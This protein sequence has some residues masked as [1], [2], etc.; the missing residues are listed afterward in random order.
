[1]ALGNTLGTQYLAV[2]HQQ[3]TQFAGRSDFA[4]KM[5]IAFGSKV[6]RDQ[7]MALGQRWLQGDFRGLP[8]IDVLYQGEL[9]TARGAYELANNKIYLSASFL[10]TASTADIVG[11]LL[12]EIGHSLDGLLN[13]GDASGDEGALFSAF[14][15]GN[16]LS[17]AEILSLQTED[18]HAFIKLNGQLLLIE[19]ATLIGDNNNNTLNGTALADLMSGLGGD[20]VISGF[21]GN[22]TL[23]GGSGSD[24]LTGGAGNDVFALEYF[25]GAFNAVNQDVVSDFVRGQDKI[26]LRSLGIG[27]LGT[28]LA[29]TND[30]NGSAVITTQYN[31]LNGFYSLRLNGISRSTL[32]AVNFIFNTSIIN[33]SKIGTINGDDLFGGQ[34]SDTLNGSAGDDRLFGEQG[35]DTLIGG[36]GSDYLTGGAGNDIFAL[37]YFTG[38]FNAVNQ[39]VVSDFMRGQ[40]K[41][42]LRSLGIGDLGTILALTNDVNGSAVITTQYNSL[43]GFYSLRLNGINRSTLSAADFIFNTNIINESKIGT[44][45]GD[46]L[47]GGQGNDTLNGS[48]G[49]D[50]LFGEQ[51][52]DNLIG[53]SGSDYLT[54]GAGNDIFALEYFAG[55]FNAVNQD[56]VSDFV[57]G[58]DKIDL[59][60]LGIGDLGTILALTNNDINGS[61]VIT[62]QYNSLNGFY[63]LR[64]NGI[65][66]STLSAANFIFNTS[67][68]NESKIGTINGDDLFGGQGNDTLNGSASND[69]LFGEQ[70]NDN[71]IGGSDS[72]Y[73]DGGFGLDVLTGG[74]GVDTFALHKAQGIDRISDFSAGDVLRLSVAEFGGGLNIGALS[75]AQVR[76]GAGV[77]RANTV[78]QRLIFDSLNRNLYFDAD[79]SGAGA[80]VQIAKLTGTAVISNLSFSIGA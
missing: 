68:I 74:A 51:G 63:S 43:N 24:Y 23:I 32:S 29:L 77:T 61:A 2:I 73:L 56:V 53:G 15:L 60:S 4:A 59:R 80:A 1:M 76:V 66:R 55:A 50:R 48:A 22:D 46:D 33:E 70:G 71:L 16:N 7:I 21:G 27:D 17:A 75:A 44:I 8:A 39:D 13:V 65:N 54:G 40:D 72:D 12:E 57:R 11:V 37:E 52:N 6:N 64:L 69:R 30:V 41:I 42:D 62:T 5:A 19:Q 14:A 78:S 79:G 31:S 67:V 36:S 35:N 49:D 45:N 3:L 28:I 34:G 38:A 20:D 9:G 26:D 47:F 25:T 10:E 58:Q 18:D